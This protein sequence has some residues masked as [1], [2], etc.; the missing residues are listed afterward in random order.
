MIKTLEKSDIEKLRENKTLS[1]IGPFLFVDNLE[2]ITK[3][4]LKVLLS[5][6]HKYNILFA[7]TFEE[8][9]N[10]YFSKKEE[11]LRIL[12]DSNLVDTDLGFDYILTK[13]HAEGIW[14]SLYTENIILKKFL[15]KR[16]EFLRTNKIYTVSDTLKDGYFGGK[17]FF[18]Y[19]NIDQIRE[20]IKYV[21]DL[22]NALDYEFEVSGEKYKFEDLFLGEKFRFTVHINT[23]LDISDKVNISELYLSGPNSL[24]FKNIKTPYDEGFNIFEEIRNITQKTE[25]TFVRFYETFLFLEDYFEVGK[26]LNIKNNEKIS[27]SF[28]TEGYNGEKD[29]I[30]N[31]INILFGPKLLKYYLPEKVYRAFYEN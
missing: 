3:K 14:N 22:I 12:L 2:F 19:K 10:R 30:T 8:V 15:L 25:R 20:T 31:Y 11:F 6:R 23:F 28:I 24:L 1:F 16:T 18:L 17:A 9:L 13:S 29:I 7:F 21:H 4:D 26:R 27:F 5:K